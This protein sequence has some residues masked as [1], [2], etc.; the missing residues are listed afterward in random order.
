MLIYL[1]R[2]YYLLPRIEL[3]LILLLLQNQ[4]KFLDTNYKIATNYFNVLFLSKLFQGWK[5]NICA[6]L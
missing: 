3:P 6:V 4:F 1:S 5:Q 2:K